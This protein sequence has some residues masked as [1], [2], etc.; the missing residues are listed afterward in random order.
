MPGSSSSMPMPG[1]IGGPRFMQPGPVPRPLE[2]EFL[3][4]WPS[5]IRTND[6]MKSAVACT[7]S[8]YFSSAAERAALVV[9]ALRR[10]QTVTR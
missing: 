8:P 2:E 10:A 1:S 6:A 7:S 9:A 4:A 3:V 5:D